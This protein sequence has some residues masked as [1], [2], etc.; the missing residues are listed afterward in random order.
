[1]DVKKAVIAFSQSEKIKAG[2]IWSSHLLE[3]VG[4]LSD[5]EKQS[6]ERVIWMLINMLLQEV[7]LAKNVTGD[8]E[9]D[10]AKKSIDQGLVMLNSGVGFDA[11]SHLTQALS[12]VTSIGQRSMTF[13]QEKGMV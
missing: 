1:M 7:Q 5:Y 13:L 2:L 8:K 6:G 10:D 3:M 12:K 4:G 9:W 11:I